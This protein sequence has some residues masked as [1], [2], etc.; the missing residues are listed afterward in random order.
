MLS[1]EKRALMQLL[2]G[3]PTF[4]RCGRDDL[5]ALVDAGSSFTLPAGWPIVSQGIPADAC[6]VLTDGNARVFHGREQIA[7]LG[8]GDIIGEMALLAGGER[9]ATVTTATQ[10][11][12]LRIENDNLV[13][14]LA[15]RPALGEAFRATYE[16]HGTPSGSTD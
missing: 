10:I 16:K 1:S 4:A 8:P 6:Y 7:M 12:G 11:G 15:H 2:S 3:Y 5:R 9:R 14:L 13:E